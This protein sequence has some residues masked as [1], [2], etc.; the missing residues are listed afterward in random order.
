ME[1]AIGLIETISIAAG[2]EITD[3]MV[4]KA[5]IRLF[6][7][8]P[9]CPGKFIVLVGGD[10]EAVKNSLQAGCKI[11]EHYLADSILISRV[12]GDVFS[13]LEAS[14]VIDDIGNLRALGVI[15]TFSVASCILAADA[16]V[17][18]GGVKLVEIRPAMGL[19]G[20]SYVTMLGD[21]SAVESAVDAGRQKAEPEGM[22]VKSVV[23]PSV[24]NDVLKA[25][26]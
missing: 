21:V 2:I 22:L 5:P 26:L 17:K 6:L 3:V 8:R 18:A 10:V 25:L 4:K 11:A 15:E 23:I 19:G 20:K 12:H 7:A 1:R 13:A 9:I 14:V 24:A 16:A